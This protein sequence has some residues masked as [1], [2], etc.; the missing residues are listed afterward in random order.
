MN[1]IKY[2]GNNLVK[3]L[4][5]KSPSSVA[6]KASNDMGMVPTSKLEDKLRKTRL[7]QFAS[8]V[9][10][11]PDIL[12]SETMKQFRFRSCPTSNSKFPSNELLN[13]SVGPF[14]LGNDLQ[15]VSASLYLKASL[16]NNIVLL[17]YIQYT[18]LTVLINNPLSHINLSITN[19]PSRIKF[20]LHIKFSITNYPHHWTIPT[21]QNKLFVYHYLIYKSP[22]SLIIN[23]TKPTKS[24][25]T[26]NL[27][28]NSWEM[29]LLRKLLKREKI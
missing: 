25:K 6:T 22:T 17:T 20:V 28:S 14:G 12:L 8:E 16:R 13:K 18:H 26:N 1:F 24:K 7:L 4:L 29:L 11:S 21:K 19:C 5:D 23:R 9:G 2:A 3:L 15:H 10:I 27:M